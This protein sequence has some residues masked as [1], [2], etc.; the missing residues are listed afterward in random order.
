M[1]AREENITKAA[2]LL[3]ITQP[4]LSRQL[5]QLE[6]E[7]GVKLFN[8]SN[9]SIV[10]T[11]DGLLLRRRAQEI[12]ALSEKTQEELSCRNGDI[13]GEISIGCGETKNMTFLSKQIS[14]FRKQYPRVR[15]QIYSANA[16]DVKERIERGLFD[17]GLLMEPVDI[18]K[19]E[20]IRMP[21][22]EQWGVIVR[23]DSPLSQKESI[24][25]ADIADV[26]LIMSGREPIKNEIASWFG[27]YYDKLEIAATFNLYVN[28]ANMVKNGVGCALCI[29]LGVSYPGVRFLPLSPKLETGAVLAWKKEQPYS[30]AARRFIE[31]IKKCVSGITENSI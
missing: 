1:T 23:N 27:D 31:D 21:H 7:L 4:T 13:S 11:E 30:A 20:F 25:P 18:S 5:M 22:R 19:Y 15:F 8:R 3:H 14:Q 17:L 28:A 16:D 12:I 9:H 10:L 6:D 26:P 24:S 29:D 2:N